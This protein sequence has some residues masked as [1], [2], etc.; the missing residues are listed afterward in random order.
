MDFP[1][2]FHWH[3]TSCGVRMGP[4][5]NHVNSDPLRLDGDHANACT[6]TF[7]HPDNTCFRARKDVR[8]R[9]AKMYAGRA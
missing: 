4:N 5:Y 3:C 1:T 8:H 7:A 9:D 6:G 2:V